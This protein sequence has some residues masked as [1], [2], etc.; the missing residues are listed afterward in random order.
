MPPPASTEF[1]NRGRLLE[2]DPLDIRQHGHLHSL[3]RSGIERTGRMTTCTRNCGDSSSLGA[4]AARRKSVSP[5]NG[6]APGSP[7]TSSTGIA[8]VTC[9]GRRRDDRRPQVHRHPAAEPPADASQARLTTYG[10]AAECG[11]PQES[12]RRPGRAPDAGFSSTSNS[13][14]PENAPGPAFSTLRRDFQRQARR[15]QRARHGQG[16]DRR[17]WVDRSVLPGSNA[18]D[19]I[20]GRHRHPPVQRAQQRPAAELRQAATGNA[21]R[22]SGRSRRDRG[23]PF[24]RGCETPRPAPRAGRSPPA[25]A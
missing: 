4:R 6:S 11:R 12:A 19:Q 5:E 13:A 1:A 25:P 24:A 20:R 14:A 10:S 23:F 9:T 18:I 21:V 22:R 15:H 7:L 2:R 16:P 8:G 17:H 3:E